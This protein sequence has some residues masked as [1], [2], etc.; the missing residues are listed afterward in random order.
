MNRVILMGRLVRDPDVRYTQGQQ[1]MCIA[2]YTLAVDRRGRKEEGQQT[3][4]FISCIAFGKSGEF[5]E[6]YL[7]KGVKICVEGHIQTGSYNDKDGNKRYTTDVVVDAHE[8][9][10]SKAANDVAQNTAPAPQ[11]AANSQQSALDSFM[12]IPDDLE[13]E[14]PFN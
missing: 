7:H 8:F 9:C 5:V 2:R 13:E 11:T 3:A 14:L 12:Q 4:D 6:K 1:P 10:E